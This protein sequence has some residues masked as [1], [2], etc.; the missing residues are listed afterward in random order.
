M[1]TLTRLSPVLLDGIDDG[2]TW[3]EVLRAG[4]H[5]SDTKRGKATRRVEVT[6]EDLAGMVKTFR[7]ALEDN[8]AGLPVGYNH[9]AMRGAVDPDSTKAA[10][11]MRALRVE[12][13]RLLAQIDWTEEGRRRVRAREFRYFS[14]EFVP[15][16]IANARDGS[17]KLA[18]P[19]V[20]GG[21]L[22]NQPFVPGMEPVAA[23]RMPETPG[24][25]SMSVLL[26]AIG[27][28][29][30]AEAVAKVAAL[31]ARVDELAPKVEILTADLARAEEKVE[32]LTAENAA[33][34]DTQREAFIERG[35]RDGR[36]TPA[37]VDGDFGVRSTLA[38]WPGEWSE[39]TA[40]VLSR[41]P[42]GKVEEVVT[43]RKPEDAPEHVETPTALDANGV[44]ALILEECVTRFALD[45]KGHVTA[46]QY[47]AVSDDLLINNPAIAPFG[48]NAAD[49]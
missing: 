42:A 47:A 30:E 4:T 21:T 35:I 46:A 40:Y 36:W 7:R 3:V 2:P 44:H 13:D 20:I 32:A 9:A 26:T 31:S 1:D 22:T 23:A 11:W 37:E 18:A 41:Y 5:E 38:K 29:D 39:K 25:D 16:S 12:G 28:D 24:D 34:L 33:L 17:G 49:A 14:I 6:A 8:K 19:I 48:G 10:G 27:A 45:N 43:E 15:A